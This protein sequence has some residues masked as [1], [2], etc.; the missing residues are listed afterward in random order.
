M[1]YALGCAERLATWIAA[2]T[3]T[4]LLLILAMARL[5]Y[6]IAPHPNLPPCPSEDS[7]VNCMWDAKVQGNGT[8][9]SFWVDSNEQVHYLED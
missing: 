4:I 9:R 2:I 1:N 6:S 5:D 8:G 3:A 7:G